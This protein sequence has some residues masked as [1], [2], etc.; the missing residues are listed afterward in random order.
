RVDIHRLD[1]RRATPG[2]M[3]SG[4]AQPDQ[5][6]TQTI[7]TGSEA[8]L[9][10]LTQG[11]VIQRDIGQALAS[12]LATGSEGSLLGLPALQKGSR[13]GIEGQAAT[14]DLGALGR[15]RLAIERQVEAE[16]VEQLRAQLALLGVHGADQHEARG[17][18]MG[19]AV[20]LDVVDP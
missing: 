1:A 18:P 17:M 10:D 2:G 9:A 3:G 11:S 19:D 12:I 5:I 15:L 13:V 14:H 16:A 4:G 20:T 7:D 6:G 8:T